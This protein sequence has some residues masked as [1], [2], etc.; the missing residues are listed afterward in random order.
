MNAA[1]GILIAADRTS[2]PTALGQDRPFDVALRCPA[3]HRKRT[4]EPLAL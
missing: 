4:A 1:V 3:I 2:A